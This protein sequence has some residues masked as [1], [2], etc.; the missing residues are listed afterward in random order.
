[1]K[2]ESIRN[3][4]RLNELSE[5]NTQQN[6]FD[7]FRQWINE[8]VQAKVNEPTAMSLSTIGTNGFPETRIV[9]L[10]GFDTEK[11][12]FYT[13]YNSR[14]GI[15]IER[16]A[17]VGLHFFWPELERQVRITGFA[18]KTCSELS[19][20]YFNSR[21]HQ[22][23]IAAV[24]SDQSAEISSR[25][26]LEEEFDALKI[27]LHGKDPGRPDNWGGYHVKPVKFEFWQGRENRLHDRITYEKSN[28][29]WLKKRLAP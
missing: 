10:K 28:N 27:K 24:I 7:Q 15:S 11:I 21:P 9:L 29:K 17:R 2:L 4:Y 8:S 14:K 18:K 19:T 20:R 23:Q 6:P 25:E 3:E 12:T 1:M 13:N 22:S 26:F 16:D 5:Q